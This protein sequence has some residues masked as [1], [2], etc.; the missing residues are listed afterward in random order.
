V[1]NRFLFLGL[2]RASLVL[3]ALYDLA[4]AATM[5]AA[6]QLPARL[7]S[8]PLPGEGFYL[9]ILAVLLT[10]LAV[11]YLVAAEDPRRYSAVVLV[12]VAGRCAG[13][14][15][16]AL[17]ARGRPELAGLWPLAGADLAFGLA[18]ATFWKLQR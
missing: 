7:L 16:L 14:A 3:G 18:H 8:L 17:A 10:M 11:L 12:G 9:S 5:V 1:R 13:A 2:L 15:A 4:F 6:P